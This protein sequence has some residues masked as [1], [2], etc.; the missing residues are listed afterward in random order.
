LRAARGAHRRRI[1]IKP[2][3]ASSDEN[4]LGCTYIK[5]KS[6]MSTRQK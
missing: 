6:R 2:S 3:L 1:V 5:A 4:D